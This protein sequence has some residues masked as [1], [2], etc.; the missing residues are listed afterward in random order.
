MEGDRDF[1]YRS[2]FIQGNIHRQGILDFIPVVKKCL[3]DLFYPGR[4]K[5]VTRQQDRFDSQR[6]CILL[7]TGISSAGIRYSE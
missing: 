5:L 6:L 7:L 1:L 4:R 3:R 2:R